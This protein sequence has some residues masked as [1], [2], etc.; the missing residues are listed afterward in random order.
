[1]ITRLEIYGKKN[2]AGLGIITII[3]LIILGV[4]FSMKTRA[5]E[6]SKDANQKFADSKVIG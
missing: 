6:L 5:N 3:V 2:Q 1:M 4:N